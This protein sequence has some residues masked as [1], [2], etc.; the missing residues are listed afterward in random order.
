MCVCT[1]VGLKYTFHDYILYIARLFAYFR[2]ICHLKRNSQDYNFKLLNHMHNHTIKECQGKMSCL[3]QIRY[4]QEKCLERVDICFVAADGIRSIPLMQCYVKK[5]IC[6]QGLKRR[7]KTR[8]YSHVY[9]F[10]LPLLDICKV[11][12]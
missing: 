9:S 12:K 8:R 7:K 2:H 1:P 11:Y 5:A 6:I 3:S 10:V 4:D